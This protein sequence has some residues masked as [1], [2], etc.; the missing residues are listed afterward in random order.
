MAEISNLVPF[1]LRFCCTSH[2]LAA[3]RSHQHLLERGTRSL[4]MRITAVVSAL[5][6]R[7]PLLSKTNIHQ[8][9]NGH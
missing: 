2:Q 7:E 4:L 3:N 6:E 9:A 8:P 5:D 1:P